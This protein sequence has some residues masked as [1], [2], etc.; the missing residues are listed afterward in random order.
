M[1]STPTTETKKRIYV[2]ADF[3]EVIQKIPNECPLIG[4]QAVSWWAQQY[5][6]ADKP[7]T[8]CDIDFWGFKENLME[9]ARALGQKPIL[10]NRHEM[11][12]WV[13]GIQMRLKG[14]TTVVDFINTVP[15]L[16]SFDAEKVSVRQWFGALSGS[17]EILVL[18]PVSLVLAKIYALKAFDQSGR[19]DERHLKVSLITAKGFIEQLLREG[20]VKHV[21]WNVERLI[22]ATQ[23]KPYRRLETQHGFHFISAIQIKNI[24]E[25]ASV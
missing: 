11:T 8:S 19:Q 17:K 3:G 20:K 13:G 22:A 5:C 23:N 2:P 16:D 1:K 15:G 9:L 21:L 14:E 12:I 6:P 7:V 25:T 4:G 18:S 10:P 24:Q